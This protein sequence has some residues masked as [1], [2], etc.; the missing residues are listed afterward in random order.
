[1]PAIV[2]RFSRTPGEVRSVGPRLGEHNDQIYS[3][4]LGL[5]A[6][7]RDRLRADGVI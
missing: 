7:E 3:D 4:L 2:P 6:A 1:M 5:D